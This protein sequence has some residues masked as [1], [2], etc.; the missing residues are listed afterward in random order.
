[1]LIDADCESRICSFSC[2]IFL[3]GWRAVEG[4]GPRWWGRGESKAKSAIS[5]PV[6]CVMFR[7]GSFFSTSFL[8]KAIHFS[9]RFGR[10]GRLESTMCVPKPRVRGRMGK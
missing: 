6:Y 10:A 1:M 9:I 3:C 5:M 7:R 4:G 8:D 2:V